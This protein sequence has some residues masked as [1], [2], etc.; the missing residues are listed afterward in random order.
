[1]SRAQI[2]PQNVKWKFFYA[3]DDGKIMCCQREDQIAKVSGSSQERNK[4]A[5]LSTSLFFGPKNPAEKMRSVTEAALKYEGRLSQFCVALPFS[6]EIAEEAPH[7][8]TAADYAGVA[9]HDIHNEKSFVG[10]QSPKVGVEQIASAIEQGFHINSMAGGVSLGQKLE[11]L[12]QY[13]R[14]NP[15]P[16]DHKKSIIAAFS[17]GS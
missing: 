2:S 16:T 13:F 4:V 15:L 5:M 10:Y 7:E 17:D 6:G 11:L 14:E 1:M 3:G 9:M 12:R 8:A